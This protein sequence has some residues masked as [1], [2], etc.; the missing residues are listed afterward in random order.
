MTSAFDPLGPLPSGTVVLEA[1]AGTGKTHAIAS[2]AVR[3]IAE[4]GLSI[5]RLL[6]ITFGSAASNELRSRVHARLVEVRDAL[7]AFTATG[8]APTDGSALHLSAHATTALARIDAALASFDAATI[9][10]THTFCR[11]MLTKLGVLAITEGTETLLESSDELAREVA[12]DLYLARFADAEPAPFAWKQAREMA[13][14]AVRTTAEVFEPARLGREAVDFVRDV[15]SEVAARKRRASLLTY[16]DWINQLL[17]SLSDPATGDL[18][19]ERLAELFPVALIDEFQDT[20]PE[21]WQV[22]RRAFVGRGTVVLIGDPKQSIYGFR[23]ADVD[24]YLEAL[25]EATT[26][27]TLVVN[28]RSDPGIVAGIGA[29]FA[30]TQLGDPRITLT[31]VT[32]RHDRRLFATDRAWDVPVK[33]RAINTGGSETITSDRAAELI[34][35]DVVTQV[36]RLLTGEVELLDDGSRRAVKPHDIAI[37]VRT[38]KRARELRQALMV[39]GVPAVFAA[40]NSIFASAAAKAW[41]ALLDAIAEPGWAARVH[42]AATSPLIGHD[43]VEIF[44]DP[45][46][47][48]I[49]G[50]AAQ[51]RLLGAVFAGS[52]PMG[53]WEQLREINHVDA[54]QLVQPG[55][56]RT[57][58]DLAHMAEL[59]HLETQRRRLGIDGLRRWLQAEIEASTRSEDAATRR[60][61]TDRDAVTILT[62]HAAKGLQFPIVL[63]PTASETGGDFGK[64]QHFV[65]PG[66]QGRRLFV[67]GAS[68][69]RA[70]ALARQE[71]FERAEELRLLY[72]AMTRAQSGVIVWWA[73]TEAAASSPLHRLVCGGPNTPV[74]AATYPTFEFPAVARSLDAGLIEVCPVSPLPPTVM[75]A[76]L[77]PQRAALARPWHRR[78]DGEWRRASYSGLTHAVHGLPVVG[79]ETA[80]TNDEVDLSVVGVA[81]AAPGADQRSPMADLPAGTGFGTLVHG[82]LEEF[83]PAPPARSARLEALVGDWAERLRIDDLDVAQLSAALELVITTP[84]GDVA[85]GLSLSEC[86]L[87][88]R[89]AELDF[90][91]PLG[92]DSFATLAALADLWRDHV[93]PGDPVAAYP[94]RLAASPAAAESLCGSLTGS[95][96]VVLGIGTGDA[97]RF[98]V[99]DYKTNRLPTLPGVELTVGHYAPAALAEAMMDAH[100]P[101]QALLYSV[102]LHRFLAWRLPGYDPHRHLGGAAYLFVR[103]MAGPK[104]PTGPEGTYGVFA[105]HPSPALVVAASALLAKGHR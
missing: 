23:N 103:G 71:E 10:T 45:H 5:D 4:E 70:D 75:D 88:A 36:Q 62:M 12:A 18:A 21:Q 32:A 13:E 8:E 73:P 33:L 98:V 63:V 65:F 11:D 87:S 27:H 52:G 35:D 6:M 60:L 91:T 42:A 102:A 49:S 78:I 95:I 19:R 34:S 77:R 79:A 59:L 93:Q 51:L 105:W 72:V 31:P 74:P 58:T 37:L 22:I 25:G 38:R 100:Y 82:V 1:S 55:G 46:R 57:L 47:T 50:A 68:S 90:D 64:R 29:L 80:E 30:D 3:Y 43:E 14:W 7:S 101:L 20:D 83:D 97:Q 86:P 40:E 85:D 94:A 69:E 39:H 99:V 41:L 24:A 81:A 26:Q 53:V 54:R 67:A 84:L 48:A 17:A 96:D 44:A 61:D 66:P 104:T 89:L 76:G 2:L 92:G 15:R 28:H 16:D 9:S 56:E